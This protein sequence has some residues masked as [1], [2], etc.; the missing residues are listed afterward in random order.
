M[1]DKRYFMPCWLL[2]FYSVVTAQQKTFPVGDSLSHKA[3]EYFI[4]KLESDE[5]TS[6]HARIYSNAYL[7][8]AKAEQNWNEIMAAY[9]GILHLSDKRTRI[10]YAD[11]MIYAAKH[12]H[13]NELIGSAYLTKGIVYYD[14]K[15]HNNALDN[16][17]LAD[18]YISSTNDR[19]LQHKIK[20]NI[21]QIKYYLGFYDEAVVLFSECV[22][23]FK[24]QE[25]VPYLTS[26]HSLGLTYN[27]LGKFDLCTAT[28]NFGIK[29]ASRIE[30]YE[31]IP[32]FVNSEGINQYF[33]KNYVVSIG[34]LQ[35][36]LPSLIK[37]K[38]FANEMV[39]YFYLGKNHWALN[40]PEKAI[41]YFFKVDKAFTKENYIRPDLRENFEL[42]INYYKQKKDLPKQLLYIN[43]LLLADKYL[44][45]NYKYLSG[46]IHKE[47]DT[48]KLLQDKNEIE[49]SLNSRKQLLAIFSVIILLLLLTVV[50]LILRARRN[51]RR[52]R[53]LMMRKQKPAKPISEKSLNGQLDINPEVVASVLKHLEKFEAN[54]KYLAKDVT[55][56]KLAKM[57]DSNIVYVSKI[58]AYSR[59]KKSVDYI[60]DLKI[61][62]IMTQLRENGK[63]RK[64]TNKA[65]GEEAGFSTTQH[66][67]R[68]FAKNT[69]ISPTYFIQE[70]N[71][72]TADSL[73]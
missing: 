51:K 71:K 56:P 38:D 69:G 46:R 25:D 49:R 47:Y 30:L 55:L 18:E 13:R 1:M 41:P 16:Y 57:F 70:L 15:E 45:D 52:F 62:H 28:N 40:Q 39:T 64:Y 58:I 9:K 14:L 23:Y 11:S 48:K 17:L 72:V 34:K 10:I 8:K 63:F 31:A 67:T 26:L 42:L 21:A 73:S 3:Y 29:E 43:Q 61:E 7:A 22:A 24:D 60:N 66:F 20:Y 59:H 12:T 68:A 44:E 35:E 36:T 65:L 2:L 50:Y 27:R 6:E 53:E 19:Y 37:S 32:R 54:E 4:E 33:Q 5:L